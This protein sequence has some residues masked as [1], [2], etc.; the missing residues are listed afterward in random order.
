MS[1]S[2]RPH[3]GSEHKV[4]YSLYTDSGGGH[5]NLAP[6]DAGDNAADPGNA[7]FVR[8]HAIKDVRIKLPSKT[9]KMLS[10]GLNSAAYAAPGKSEIGELEI[11]AGFFPTV[12][13]VPVF[14]NARMDVKIETYDGDPDDGGICVAV[15][16][17]TDWKPMIDRSNPEGD[18]ESTATARG[19]Y[20]GYSLTAVPGA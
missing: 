13:V 3:V 8:L 10:D 12:G 5:Q 6:T 19:Q 14:E 18:G 9:R 4:Y 20:L 11:Q 7:A 1:Y 2:P 17:I 16:K 15:T